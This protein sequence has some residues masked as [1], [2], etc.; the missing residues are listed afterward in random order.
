M[1]ARIGYTW[2]VMG[3]SWQV[4]KKD[5][6]LLVFALL[7]TVACLIVLA[8]FAIPIAQ[9]E[10]WQPPTRE[11]PPE[12]QVYYYGTL[13][14]FYFCNYF[15]IT[16]FNCAI[17]SCA[18][19]RLS[20]GDPTL[21][22]G[23]RTATARLPYILGW[24]L[25]SATVGLILR[26]IEDRSE[27]VGRFVAGLLGMAW[28]L[29]SFLVVPVLVVEGLGPFK[30]L[31]RSTALLK[32]TWGEQVVGGFSFGAIGFLLMIPGIA[33][34]VVGFVAG[35]KIALAVCVG[36]GVLDIVAVSLVMSTLR[37]IF[38]AAVYHYAEHGQ[39]PADFDGAM[40][41]GAMQRK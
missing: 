3:S 13:F 33:L 21:A 41:A 1:F 36:V 9:L 30:S 24:A 37:T 22:D 32:K 11:A 14:L 25:V 31:G 5:K 19:I 39:A 10:N 18:V 35:S 2:E 28:T 29:V 15:V 26:I 6:E 34:L 23:F 7:S 20:G 16:Y 12:Q 27:K 4:L 8:S 40:L 17:V 38:Q